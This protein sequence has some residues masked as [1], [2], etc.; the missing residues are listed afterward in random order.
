MIS[1]RTAVFGTKSQKEIERLRPILDRIDGMRGEMMR[2]SDE[3]MKKKTE[4]FRKRIKN[5][6]APGHILP[7]AFALV[8]EA[9]RRVLGMEHFRVQMAGGIIL[10]RGNIAQMCT[11]EGKTLVATLPAYLGALEGNG[12]HIVTVNDY[13]AKR[14]AEWMGQVYNFLGLS[15]GVVLQGM[16]REERK[17]AY[18]CDITYVT[19]SEVGFDY[20]RD[21]MA[22]NLGDIVLRGLNYAIIDEADSI[23]IDEARTPLIIAG[24]TVPDTVMYKKCDEFAKS[25]ER[26]KDIPELTKNDILAGSVAEETGDFVLNEKE[27]TWSITERGVE[28]AERTFGIENYADLKNLH[29]QHGVDNAVRANYLMKKD[30]DYIVRDDA[31]EL[32]DAFTGRVMEGRRFSDGLH[33]AIEAKE[34][35]TVTGENQTLAT[36]TY[37]S[38][39]NKYKKRCGMTGTAET[40]RDEFISVYGMDVVE[41][42][43]NRPVKRVDHPDVMYKTKAGK[44]RAVVEVVKEANAKGQPVLIGTASIDVSETL[45][46]MFMKEGLPHSVLNAKNHEKEAEIV[47]DAGKY[48]AIT[49]AT[50]MAGRGTDIKPDEQALEAGGLLVLG[51]ERHESRRIDGQLRGRSGRQGDPGES[52]F[53]V[54]L[55]D[56]LLRLFGGDN[57]KKSFDRLKVGEDEGISSKAITR[58]IENA[59][60]KIESD[61]FAT[62]KQLLDFDMI[63]NEQRDDIYGQRM[64]LLTGANFEAIISN[65]VE[66]VSGG[67]V[68]ALIPPGKNGG[69]WDLGALNAALGSVFH[70]ASIPDEAVEGFTHD[71]FKEWLRGGILSLYERKMRSYLGPKAERYRMRMAILYIIDEYWKQHLNNMEILEQNIRLQSYAGRDP[72]LAYRTASYEMFNTL[73]WMV[74]IDGLTAV[75]QP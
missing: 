48:G 29:V 42:P 75:F 1:L 30:R 56:D 74:M 65:M 33:Q 2:L 52:V 61:N 3:E 31:I 45:S 12:V 44:Y 66:T 54:S 17:E 58:A 27:K 9:S 73:S 5:G 21:N 8:R 40:E 38:F 55:E 60:K 72:A 43:T 49:I 67:L 64:E 35:V 63:L 62:R 70:M 18:A 22:V 71:E 36:I 39:F 47:K 41:I 24:G 15:V 59:Q 7:E 68:D 57:T 37:Q 13:L 6:E 10:Y 50:D 28:K 19:N 4:E 23:L 14:D 51:T 32:I 25:M 46:G 26:G 53:Y 20:L 69:K 34:G 16:N 11:G